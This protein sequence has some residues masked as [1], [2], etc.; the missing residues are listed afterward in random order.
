MEPPSKHRRVGS[1]ECHLSKRLGKAL[2]LHHVLPCL[3]AW[4]RACLLHSLGTVAKDWRIGLATRKWSLV[5]D[6]D[7]VA[8]QNLKWRDRVF[9]PMEAVTEAELCFRIPDVLANVCGSVQRLTCHG[10]RLENCW[11]AEHTLPYLR[12]LHVSLRVRRIEEGSLLHLVVTALRH[13]PIETLELCQQKGGADISFPTDFWHNWLLQWP[14]TWTNSLRRIVVRFAKIKLTRAMLIALVHK[15]AVVHHL[16]W[17]PDEPCRFE[18]HHPP[19]TDDALMLVAQTWGD[20]L[21]CLH[22][23]TGVY[24]AARGLS[25]ES[26]VALSRACPLIEEM[27]IGSVPPGWTLQAMIDAVQQWPRLRV[28]RVPEKCDHRLMVTLARVCN[29][30]ENVRGNRTISGEDD[31]TTR[32]LAPRMHHWIPGLSLPVNTALSL[33]LESLVCTHTIHVCHA[34]A[35]LRAAKRLRTVDLLLDARDEWTDELFVDMASDLLET[36]RLRTE[37]RPGPRCRLGPLAFRQLARRRHRLRSC[38]LGP[39]VVTS[40]HPTMDHRWRIDMHDLMDLR[41]APTLSRLLV[42]GFALEPLDWEPYSVFRHIHNNAQ[43]F[44]GYWAVSS[45]TP[46]SIRA[47][48]CKLETIEGSSQ[49]TVVR[50]LLS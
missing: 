41:V 49:G 6:E 31:H 7:V 19:F 40:E 28:L 21:Q 14:D 8:Y 43:S 9:P 36:L 45:E 11:L 30:L 5:E 16:E 32:L 10:M 17:H 24:D 1:R 18:V 34:A 23:A 50:I 42:S 47:Q 37:T 27:D 20:H 2:I 25:S 26:L 22:V 33:D 3:H 13:N 48:M 12:H 39:L 29:R 15:C 38:E 35:I 4:E 46:Y 44:G